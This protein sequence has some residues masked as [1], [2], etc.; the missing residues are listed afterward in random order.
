MSNHAFGLPKNRRKPFLFFLSFWASVSLAAASNT[1]RTPS[2][3][4]GEHSK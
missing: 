4:K 2:F 1:L 3:V